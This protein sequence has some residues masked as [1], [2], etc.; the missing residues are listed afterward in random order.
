MRFVRENVIIV[1]LNVSF[2]IHIFW[3]V[4]FV[5]F[6]FSFKV[7]VIKFDATKIE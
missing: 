4:H 7:Y 3:K 2:Y 1:C 6:Y 5:F